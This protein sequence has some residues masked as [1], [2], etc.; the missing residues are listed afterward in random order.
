MDD[1]TGIYL[2]ENNKRMITNIRLQFGNTA[3]ALAEEGKQDKALEV[4]HKVVEITPEINVPYDRVM[5]PIAE[6][7]WRLGP[8]DT[9]GLPPGYE[10]ALSEELQK[11]AQAEGKRISTRLFDIFEDD[12]EYFF[13]LEPEFAAKYVNDMEIK[14]SVN[15]RI[16]L[17]YQFYAPDDDFGYELSERLDSLATQFEYKLQDI[18]RVEF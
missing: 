11:E 2:D 3:E 12:L 9:L 16:T 17:L 10:T 1:T 6:N 13:S 5:L 14:M 8:R 7:F 4:L 15:N 18:G